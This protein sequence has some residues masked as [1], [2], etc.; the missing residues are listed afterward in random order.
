M[1]LNYDKV[2]LGNEGNH[3]FQFQ[4]STSVTSILSRQNF[5]LSWQIPNHRMWSMNRTALSSPILCVWQLK[6]AGLFR[7][8]E[9]P[10]KS[11]AEFWQVDYL[12]KLSV[13]QQAFEDPSWSALSLGSTLGFCRHKSM[14]RQTQ[15]FILEWLLYILSLIFMSCTVR[16]STD[17][18]DSYS[19]ICHICCWETE[20][21]VQV[22]TLQFILVELL[23][24]LGT[25]T[26]S[27]FF[28][29]V[30]FSGAPWCHGAMFEMH[31]QY[32]RLCVFLHT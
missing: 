31:P 10:E 28:F 26:Q 19:H 32:N 24:H 20:C 4:Y 13:Q 18:D 25:F 5:G 12:K 7:D 15:T 23:Q 29:L 21:V 27:F 30:I 11:R 3:Q 1:H 6:Q 2:I 17:S 16:S 22:Y 9:Q 8:T 14:L